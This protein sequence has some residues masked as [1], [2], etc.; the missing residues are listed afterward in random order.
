ME[1]DEE[2]K[3]GNEQQVGN[4]ALINEV[5][6]IING[7]GD[8]KE[9]AEEPEVN[10]IEIENGIEDVL[11][12][13]TQPAATQTKPLSN[14]IS[15]DHTHNDINN[16]DGNV[17]MVNDES[18]VAIVNGD[19]DVAMVN[20]DSDVA[21]VNGNTQEKNRWSFP[22]KLEDFDLMKT[23]IDPSELEMIF[24]DERYGYHGNVNAVSSQCYLNH[25][26]T[27]TQTS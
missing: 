17:A 11:P 19:S 8:G 9:E 27:H 22:P 15:D 6:P 7:A 26:H 3:A 21:M 2:D 14:G 23:N 5:E 18:D 16:Y 12:E 1:T 4:S 10:D 24:L 13:A 20:G 25:T